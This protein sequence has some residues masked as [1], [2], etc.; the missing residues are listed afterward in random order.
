M[1]PTDERDLGLVAYF[2]Y[3]ALWNQNLYLLTTSK[4]ES[5]SDLDQT[6]FPVTE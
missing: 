2:D 6:V 4:P 3:F 1:K 5:D